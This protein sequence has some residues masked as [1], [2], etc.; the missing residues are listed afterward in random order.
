MTRGVAF[1]LLAAAGAGAALAG[2]VVSAPLPP[3]TYAD[4]EVR[5][6]LALPAWAPG[7]RKFRF[8]LDFDAT[9]SNNVQVAFGNDA[10]GDGALSGDE[11]GMMIGWDCGTWFVRTCAADGTADGTSAAAAA[12]RKRLSFGLRLRGGAPEEPP[13]VR[14]GETAIF[15]AWAAGHYAGMHDKTWDM[16]RL[17]ARGVDAPGE[18]FEASRSQDGFSIILR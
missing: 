15:T 16:M 12:G 17:T 2:G 14:D 7:V 1:L 9:A 6:D 11:T 10:D 8:T 13:D 18:R 3:P 4:T 5:E